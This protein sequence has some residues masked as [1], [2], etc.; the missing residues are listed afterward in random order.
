MELSACWALLNCHHAGTGS[1]EVHVPLSHRCYA[2][3]SQ[4]THC[5]LSYIRVVTSWEGAATKPLV[6]Q[7]RS[8]GTHLFGLSSSVP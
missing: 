2:K 1:W 4:L 8:G 5:P 3:K 6:P 7:A